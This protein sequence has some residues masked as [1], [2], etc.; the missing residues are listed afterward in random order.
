M[1]SAPPIWLCS[2][3]HLFIVRLAATERVLSGGL[4]AYHVELE[5][6]EQALQICGRMTP[7]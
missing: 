1:R 5:G 2:E 4:P 7:R 6:A 3:H